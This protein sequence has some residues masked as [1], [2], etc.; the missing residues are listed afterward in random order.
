LITGGTGM[1]GGV[2]AEHLVSAY[3]MRQLLLVSRGG[4]DAPGAVE[5]AARLSALGAAVTMAACDGSDRAALAAVLGAVSP[6]HPLTAVVHA[7]GVLDDAVLSELTAEQLDAVLTAKADS[8]WHLHELTAGLDLAAFVLFS[9][10][11]GILGAPGQANYAAANAVLDALAADRYRHQLPATSVAWGYWQT[12]SGMTAHL[13]TR[14]QA[15]VTGPGGLAP[16]T[17]EHGKAMFDTALAQQQPTVVAVPINHRARA[18][19]AGQHGVPAL[20]SALITARPQAAASAGPQALTVRLAG[21]TAQQRHEV[22]TALVI[23]TTAMVLAHPDPGALDAERPF[24]DLGIDSLTALELR[25]SLST[26][27]G[28]SLPATL[29]FDHPS[30]A[31]IAEHICAQLTGIAPGHSTTNTEYVKQIHELITS[32]PANRLVQA[33]LLDFLQELIRD[34][35]DPA[36]HEL[37]KSSLAAMGLDDLVNV[38]LDDSWDR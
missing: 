9:S 35:G 7:A 38:A 12:P 21:L 29:V 15:R 25:N 14:D 11:A 3:G 31:A 32:I 1:L 34:D 22:L 30:P 8:A 13:G 33:N 17:A 27:T 37:K 24:K 36:I 19:Q 23:E 5:L 6:A 16:I 28:L 2:F 4:A 20:L 10:A 18:R 26:Q